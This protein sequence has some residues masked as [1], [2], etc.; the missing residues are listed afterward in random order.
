M[1]PDEQRRHASADPRPGRRL[2]DPADDSPGIGAVALAVNPGV[3]VVGDQ[4]V[5]EATLLRPLSKVN[6]TARAVLLARQ[7][8]TDLDHDLGSPT[9][10]A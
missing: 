10:L 8:V 9:M 7:V 6:Q 1:V 2:S 3:I 4:G 5:A